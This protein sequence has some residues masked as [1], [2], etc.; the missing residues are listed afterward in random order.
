M[1]TAP[2]SEYLTDA[3]IQIPDVPTLVS[4]A[5]A[6]LQGAI[7]PN[8][9]TSP[10]TVIGNEIATFTAAQRAAYEDIQV[11]SCGNDPNQAEGFVLDGIC[12]F[13]N[14]VRNPA[15]SSFFSGVRQ[16][17]VGLDASTTLAS[18]S[19]YFAQA[20]NVS[21]R[22]AMTSPTFTS[23]SL[24][25]ADGAVLGTTGSGPTLFYLSGTGV[26]A[27][28]GAEV[29]LVSG[30]GTLVVPFVF[31]TVALAGGLGLYYPGTT[32]PVP[33]DDPV[34]SSIIA[35]AYNLGGL[36]IWPAY[37]IDAVCSGTG[38]TTCNAGTLTV[39]QTPQ[40]GLGC[41]VNPEDAYLGTNVETDTAL[42]LRRFLGLRALGSGST[43]AIQ[44]ALLAIQINGATAVVFATV[45]ENVQIYVDTS[46]LLPPKSM[47]A[48]VFDGL[49]QTV[50]N[51]LI[52]QTIW[53]NKPSGI[54]MVGGSSGIAIDTASSLPQTVLF[55]RPYLTRLIVAISVRINAKTQSFLGAASV[56]AAI[57]A[58]SAANP[59]GVVYFSQV[60]TAGTVA[61][62]LGVESIQLG[63]Y[64][65]GLL[66]PFQD[67]NPGSN[68]ITYILDT[69]TDVIV[70]VIS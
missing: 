52:A 60:S 1:I 16:V 35:T 36:S 20:G 55:D 62:V 70:T 13:T 9:D 41:V 18:Q 21:V 56:Q 31:P 68:A 26:N 54:Q 51:S 7:D 49:S 59:Q 15:T 6:A 8:L 40:T 50:P 69:L 53:N 27:L 28:I 39:I 61:G 44:S 5:A 33:N 65:A 47:R 29:L 10:E 30:D 57:A 64:G 32:T 14:T 38:P 66:E 42:R 67:L 58:W 3:G 25:H 45:T 2:T 4:N 12:S 17:A 37:M 63:I 34:V 11:L 23:G 24:G 19:V 43:A 48:L 22:F 46:T